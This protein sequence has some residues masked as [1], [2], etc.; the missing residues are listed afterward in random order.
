MIK[1][2]AWTREYHVPLLNKFQVACNEEDLTTLDPI[3]ITH[4]TF[5]ATDD[6]YVAENRRSYQ[7][8]DLKLPK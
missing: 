1:V 6:W 5:V 4:I 3:E 2:P 7:Y 8:F